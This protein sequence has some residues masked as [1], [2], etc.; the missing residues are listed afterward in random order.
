VLAP[1]DDP[2]LQQA[3]PVWSIVIRSFAFVRKEVVEIVR[4]PRLVALLVLGPFLLLL[5]F[6]SGYAETDIQLRAVFVGPEGS[7][8][9]D[10]LD[11]Y[12]D[13]L[14][15]YID[16]KGLVPTEA[17]GRRMLE[18]G[19]VDVVV[20]FPEEPERTVMQG[21]RAVIGILHDE[22]DPIQQGAIE[23][24]AR[25]AIQE[26]NATVLATLA[27]EAQEQ[28]APAGELGD[29]LVAAGEALPD[30]PVGTRDSMSSTFS[31][32]G[33]ALDGS[34]NILDRLGPDDP[35]LA[36]LQQTRDQADELAARV[37]AVDGD[38]SDEDLAELTA[39][40]QSLASELDE[41]VVLDPDVLVRPFQ[42]ETDNVSGADISPTDYFTPASLALL[43]QHLA[44]TFAA[45]SVVRD[46]RTG[47][48]ELMRVG[49]LSSI[50]IIVGK[51]LAYLL[52]GAVVGGAHVAAAVYGLGITIVGS[53]G[54]LVAVL[55]G[56]LLASLALG[57][58]F[59]LISRSESQA[60]QF[61][62]LLL[63]AGL[64]FSGFILPLEGLTYPVKLISWTL[65]V[66]YGIQNL[67]DVML[68]GTTPDPAMIA[69]LAGLVLVYG[70]IAVTGL[71]RRLR[72]SE[73]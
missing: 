24:A 14:S 61:A 6:G 25:L 29:E 4:Q 45:L 57:M 34:V 36:Q 22:I 8:Y 30:D 39:S 12:E 42:S 32:L 43:L 9:D 3:G 23:V 70:T 54:W 5:L 20:I 49:P 67:Q 28:L 31:R 26:V 50:E 48:F 1:R 71:R 69:G 33:D 16:S 65:P 53:I 15:E 63:L 35:A 64:F 73:A 19:D 18:D 68:R 11:T 27:S 51:I 37:A 41:A 13:E 47:L 72:T 44:L 46:R 10:V 52:V 40:I 21:E 17:E 7:I 58:V 66:T 62:M 56:V 59:A 38:T 2:S 60:V 55:V